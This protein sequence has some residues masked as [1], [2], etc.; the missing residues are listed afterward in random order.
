VLPAVF[1]FARSWVACTDTTDRHLARITSSP[2]RDFYLFLQSLCAL[3]VSRHQCHLSSRT[4]SCCVGPLWLGAARRCSAFLGSQ[5]PTTGH[6]WVAFFTFDGKSFF[7]RLP[8]RPRLSFLQPTGLRFHLL[9]DAPWL[10]NIGSSYE[11]R[12]SIPLLV[13]PL[14]HPRTNTHHHCLLIWY[15][16]CGGAVL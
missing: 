3:A 11:T 5:L 1:A 2:Y 9:H 4:V 14:D 13:R 16:V 8:P 12:Q 15:L 7:L 6:D 10:T